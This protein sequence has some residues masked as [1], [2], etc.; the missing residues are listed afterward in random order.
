MRPTLGRGR[1]MAIAALAAAVASGTPAGA[2]RRRIV[3]LAIGPFRIEANRDREVCQAVRVRGVPGMEVLS[4]SVRSRTSSAG[5]VGTHHFA[6]YGYRGS[7]SRAFPAGLADDPGCNGFGPSDFYNHRVSLAGSGGER[8]RGRWLVTDSAV[9]PGLSQPLPNPTDAPGD[10]L[11]VLNSHYFNDS[12]RPARGYARLRLRLGPA[13]PHKRVLRQLLAVDASRRI[14]VAPGTSGS[15]TATWQA[16]GAEN[17]DTEGGANPAGDVCLLY[18]T[19]HMHKRGARFMLAYEREG[20]PMEPPLLDFTD[21]VHPA[22]VYYVRGFLL[23]AHTAENGHPLFRYTC[24][25]ANGTAGKTIKTGCETEPGMT[26]GTSWTDA[27]ARGISP[28]ESHARPCG[29]AGVNCAGFGTGR[30]VPANLVFGPLSDDD[31]CILVGT[32]YD[33]IPGLP[34]EQACD[35]LYRK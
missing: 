24:E 7:D 34:P 35:P 9:P 32:V 33:P 31:M 14:D 11:I 12:A 22:V 25:H 21:Y 5:A 1:I 27:A 10:A 18:L 15:E 23:P 16:D 29:E 3:D 17:P 13:D 19:G 26:P 30:C 20:A 6:A 2:A 28:L 4:Y 8:R